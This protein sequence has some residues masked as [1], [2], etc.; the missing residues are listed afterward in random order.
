MSNFALRKFSKSEKKKEQ[1][2]RRYLMTTTGS[3]LPTLLSLLMERIRRLDSSESRIMP[4]GGT[5]KE[6]CEPKSIN[7]SII[8][9]KTK[10]EKYIPLLRDE[11]KKMNSFITINQ[12]QKH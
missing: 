2:R 4:C 6:T 11:V 8:Q 1:E 3:V 12:Q 5:I 9:A 7:Q 10:K